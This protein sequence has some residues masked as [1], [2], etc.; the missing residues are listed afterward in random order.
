MFTIYSAREQQRAKKQNYKNKTLQS[1][2][3][4]T[5]IIQGLDTVNNTDGNRI[6]FVRFLLYTQRET[7]KPQ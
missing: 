7:T 2:K 3:C 5:I 6:F 1:L 4:V